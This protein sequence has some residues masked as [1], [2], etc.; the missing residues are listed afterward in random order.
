[1][2]DIT[3][4]H[5]MGLHDYVRRDLLALFD[6]LPVG[7]SR[8]MREITAKLAHYSPV[9]VESAVRALVEEKELN[10]LQLTI[11]TRL[12]SRQQAYNARHF[13]P[14]FAGSPEWIVEHRDGTAIAFCTREFYARL[15]TESLNRR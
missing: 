5:V 10:V 8:T 11:S 15:I 12:Y 7:D 6:K 14:L 9:L 13:T 3:P 1:M 4:T 2:N